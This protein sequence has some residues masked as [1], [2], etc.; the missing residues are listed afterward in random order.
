MNIKEN[1]QKED[2]IPHSAAS[3]GDIADDGRGRANTSV[4][5]F[6]LHP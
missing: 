1:G 5:L 4:Q 6:R 3:S 2:K